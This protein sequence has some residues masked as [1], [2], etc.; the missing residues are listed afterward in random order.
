MSENGKLPYIPFYYGDFLAKTTHLDGIEKAAYVFCI[1]HLWQYEFANAMQLQRICKA[2]FGQWRDPQEIWEGIKEFFKTNEEGLYYLTRV[3]KEREHAVQVGEK[4]RLAAKKSHEK[5]K[6]NTIA[7]ELQMQSNCNAN[8]GQMLC[9]QNQN[10][11]H[12]ELDSLRS[13]NSVSEHAREEPA[14]P[15]PR[16]FGQ[17]PEQQADR[18][19]PPSLERFLECSQSAAWNYLAL[20]P[21]Q[22]REIWHEGEMIEWRMIDGSRIQ[23]WKHWA[24]K[25]AKKLKAAGP[26]PTP[27]PGYDRQGKPIPHSQS[28]EAARAEILRQMKEVQ[29][30]RG[31]HAAV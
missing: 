24:L 30:K 14:H 3:N 22:W 5:R 15:T 18:N 12:I 25:Q 8:A 19:A 20:T 2:N 16:S 17:T 7:N 23:D 13:S 29:E 26:A 10:Q 4:R 28:A 27:K 6:Q 11:N 21:D 9:N 31:I 1:M